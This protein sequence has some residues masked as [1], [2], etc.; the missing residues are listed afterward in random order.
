MAPRILPG[1]DESSRPYWTGGAAGELRIAH[2]GSCARFVHPPR[3]ECAD[4]GATLEDVAVSGDGTLFTYT[5]AYQQFHPDVP[6]PFVIALV[7]LN[8]Q[9]GLRV[10]TNIVDCDPASLVS[11]MPVRVR[12][13][14]HDLETGT[15]FVP[16][17]APADPLT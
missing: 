13:E 8:E 10:V 6:P 5:I 16:V 11:G 15:V 9:R 1:V 2:C 7:E 17:F 3:H 14:Q 4:C 12:F